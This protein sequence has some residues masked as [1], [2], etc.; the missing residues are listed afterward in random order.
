MTEQYTQMK[1]IS[2]DLNGSGQKHAII[3]ARW[4][5]FI[6]SRL[7][8]GARDA[9]LRHGVNAADI[10]FVYVPG[11]FEIGVVAKK[12]ADSGKYDAVSCLAAVIRGSTAHFD[13]VAGTA[14]RLVAQAGYDSGLP[15]I[16][17]VL[18]TDTIEQA[19]ERAGIKAGNKGFE[20]AATAVEMA[21]LLKKLD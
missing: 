17:G 14:A 19:M 21:S 10:T 12:L 18:T 20:A 4:N 3:V 2:G 9:L 5:D 11:A 13:Y 7:E 16:F 1:E 15:V 8:V 6:T